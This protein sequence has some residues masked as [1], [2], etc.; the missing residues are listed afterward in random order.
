ME[1]DD[2]PIGLSTH[3]GCIK[4]SYVVNIIILPGISFVSEVQ[5]RRKEF[6]DSRIFL[7]QLHTIKKKTAIYI[8]L[9]KIAKYVTLLS[10]ISI[11][12]FHPR[13]PRVVLMSHKCPLKDGT[14]L[15]VALS[16]KTKS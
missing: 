10:I 3:S 5:M 14:Q 8:K 6:L 2:K 15:R 16:V 7:Q 1:S 12:S 13:S 11:S 4:A 9:L